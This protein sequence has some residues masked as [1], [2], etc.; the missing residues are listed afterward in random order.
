MRNF[1]GKS[2]Q[3][4]AVYIRAGMIPPFHQSSM[5]REITLLKTGEGAR[6][7]KAKIRKIMNIFDI[8]GVL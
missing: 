1:S 4:Q 7:G 2:K 3:M 5:K 8:Q 6:D